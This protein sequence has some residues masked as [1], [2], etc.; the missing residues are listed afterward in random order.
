MRDDLQKK[1]DANERLVMEDKQQHL[2]EQWMKNLDGMIQSLPNQHLTFEE[3]LRRIERIENDLNQRKES[4]TT[5]SS[6]IDQIQRDLNRLRQVTKH[7]FCP[8][9]ENNSSSSFRSSNVEIT[10]RKI[11][12]NESIHFFVISKK[13]ININ[14]SVINVI[15][16]HFNVNMND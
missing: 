2:D 8:M 12:V 11:F 10:M 16:P 3:K 14:R 9:I 4:M 13:I 6:S 5:F 15:Y 1:I 7:F